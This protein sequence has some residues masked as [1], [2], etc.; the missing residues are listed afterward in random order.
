MTLWRLVLLMLLLATSTMVLSQEQ[1]TA[2][3]AEEAAE[4][5][6]VDAAE[7]AAA[8]EAEI[9]AAEAAAAAAA[10]RVSCDKVLGVYFVFRFHSDHSLLATATIRL[11]RKQLPPLL[12]RRQKPSEWPRQPPKR[13]R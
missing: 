2:A 11:E 1:G 9:K 8:A 3:A 12:L 13:L 6:D 5:L 4:D 10:D 7:A